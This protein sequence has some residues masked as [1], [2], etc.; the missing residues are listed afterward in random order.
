[1][2]TTDNESFDSTRRSQI[3]GMAAGL[4]TSAMGGAALYLA[5]YANAKVGKSRRDQESLTSTNVYVAQEMK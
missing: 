3:F 2:Q 5:R 1:M 4:S